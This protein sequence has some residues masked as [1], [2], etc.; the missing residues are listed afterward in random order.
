MKLVIKHAKISTFFNIFNMC[1]AYTAYGK[2]N[3]VIKIRSLNVH[4]RIENTYDIS[5]TG[6]YWR[7]SFPVG[8]NIL[9]ISYS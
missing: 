5:S 1:L 6:N 4:L 2:M 9:K 7:K 8:A 3:K